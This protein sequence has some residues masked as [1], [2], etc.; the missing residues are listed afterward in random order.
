MIAIVSSL[1]ILVVVTVEVVAVSKRSDFLTPA[2]PAPWKWNRT[3]PIFSN[4]AGVAS[5]RSQ[6]LISTSNHTSGH[7]ATVREDEGGYNWEAHGYT[8]I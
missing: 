8:P 2:A 6:R 4:S 3:E 1:V 7:V 5:Q